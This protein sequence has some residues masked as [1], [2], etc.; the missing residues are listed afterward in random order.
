MSV[1]PLPWK[2]GKHENYTNFVVSINICITDNQ[3][4]S[5]KELQDVED[6]ETVSQLPNHGLEETQ[7]ALLVE[8]CK[9][10]ALL[11][12]LKVMSQGTNSKDS[13]DVL[14]QNVKEVL[15]KS[16]DK[17]VPVSVDFV[18]SNVVKD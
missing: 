9:L 2:K 14:I 16:I 12:T 18:L 10:E 15:S 5:Y 8:A 17:L 1:P 6:V 11:M 4:V 7:H 13:R 3:V